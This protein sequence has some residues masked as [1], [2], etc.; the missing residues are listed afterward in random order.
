MNETDRKGCKLAVDFFVKANPKMDPK[1]LLRII[2][3]FW[4]DTSNLRSMCKYPKRL[5]NFASILSDAPT[6]KM[7]L[8]QM[9]RLIVLEQ[10]MS[11]YSQATAFLCMVNS[12]VD[13]KT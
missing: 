6:T 11:E 7:V 5:P 3:S 8:Q 2:E 10:G 12:Y 1:V 4:N 13:L 9:Y